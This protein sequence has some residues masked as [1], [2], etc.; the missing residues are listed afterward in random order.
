MGWPPEGADNFSNS[1]SFFQR[2]SVIFSKWPQCFHPNFPS[3]TTEIPQPWSG[4]GT[5]EAWAC[6]G[7]AVLWFWGAELRR[8]Q[9]LGLEWKQPQEAWQV[10]KCPS[11][12]TVLMEEENAHWRKCI[13]QQGPGKARDS[14]TGRMPWARLSGRTGAFPV[15]PTYFNRTCRLA[16]SLCRHSRL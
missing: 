1:F 15:R 5:Q 11:R 9:N 16:T 12:E 8:S 14:E 2:F 10:P 13:L 4:E 3:Q 7:R 6:Q